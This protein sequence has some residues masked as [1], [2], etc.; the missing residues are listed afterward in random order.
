VLELRDGGQFV[1]VAF[2]DLRW[3]QRV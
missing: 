3:P 2:P 1:I